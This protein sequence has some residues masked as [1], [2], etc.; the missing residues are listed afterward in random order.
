MKGGFLRGQ[1]TYGCVF[2]PALLCRGSKNPTDPNKVG[3]ITSYEDA[4]NELKIGK[5]LRTIDGYQ[6]YVIPA[7]SDSCI[8]RAKSRQV[9]KDID[10]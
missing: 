6:N 2:Q 7:E 5:Y 1:G 4:K 9:D 10:K 3:K 8:P